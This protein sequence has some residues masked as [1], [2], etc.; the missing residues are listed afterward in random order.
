MV[1][2]LPS[3]MLILRSFSS[4]H[5]WRQRLSQLY[6]KIIKNN[7][8]L[9]HNSAYPLQCLSDPA[10]GCGIGEPDIIFPVR[11]EGRAGGGGDESLFEQPVGEGVPASQ[12][13][14]IGEDIEGSPGNA[15]GYA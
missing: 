5:H 13:G 8:P 15:A 11:P 12:M 10:P 9:S 6:Y 1:E 14:E 2:D 3:V 4:H 7:N